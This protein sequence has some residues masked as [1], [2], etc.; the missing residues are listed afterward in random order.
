MKFYEAPVGRM[1][2]RVLTRAP[3]TKSWVL[4]PL[5]KRC[6]HRMRGGAG[7]VSQPNHGLKSWPVEMLLGF[8]VAPSA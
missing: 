3:S 4:E 2:N 8:G 6:C 7:C 5:V 1:D